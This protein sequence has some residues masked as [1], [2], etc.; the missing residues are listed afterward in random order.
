MDFFSMTN[1][2]EYADGPWNDTDALYVDQSVRVFPS[3][4]RSPI[5]S[6]SYEAYRLAIQKF[7]YGPEP[8]CGDQAHPYV[9]ADFNNDCIVN[10][11]DFCIFINEW[12][13]SSEV[14]DVTVDIPWTQGT[15]INNM[16]PN[17]NYSG[18]WDMQLVWDTSGQRN[19]GLWNF[20]MSLLSG[21]LYIKS[22]ELHY[23][24]YYQFASPTALP[25]YSKIH[26]VL[27][28]WDE[29]TTTWNSFYDGTGY[30][31]NAEVLGTMPFEQ[32]DTYRKEVVLSSPEMVQMVQDWIDNPANA[33]GLLLQASDKTV[34]WWMQTTNNWLSPF[35]R[36]TYSTNHPDTV[37]DL[38]GDSRIDFSDLAL[39]AA[40]WLNC[41]HP[42]GC[43][44][45]DFPD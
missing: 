7:K 10:F 4:Y 43:I 20:D 33:N 5:W 32:V 2:Y 36:V 3:A 13:G 29:F 45:Y 31:Y 26:K 25:L 18:R 30:Y 38:N 6:R 9:S 28:P 21:I 40:S 41:T 44:G 14:E 37:G 24:D 15:M 16:N 23:Y 27:K 34:G 35:L 1:F 8:S 39:I 42:S 17:T 22:V 12:N 19:Q 11:E